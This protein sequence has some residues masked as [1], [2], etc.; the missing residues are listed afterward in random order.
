MQ[1]FFQLWS[2]LCHPVLSS[3]QAD[4]HPCQ[5]ERRA[6]TVQCTV[7]HMICSVWGWDEIFCRVVD[8]RRFDGGIRIRRSIFMLF[9]IR[10][11]SQV[12]MENQN[13]VW[14]LFTP[15]PVLSLHCFIFLASVI[16]RRC[17][18]FN[19]S[20]WILKIFW[21]RVPIVLV[22]YL[23]EIDRDL[24]PPK[25]CRSAQTRIHITVF[26]YTIFFCRARC[27]VV[28]WLNSET[29]GTK[30]HIFWTAF[31]SLQLRYS[32]TSVSDPDSF[33]YGSGFRF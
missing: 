27:R 11:L 33:C 15:V 4:R 1:F 13:F 8:R 22:L 6:G 18:N 5:Q 30:L 24:D 29:S 32:S 2:L 16:L 3:S 28:L 21:K 12:F 9:W 19:I 7:F 14:I 25:W 10:I 31:T 26:L 20:S 17:H 23:V